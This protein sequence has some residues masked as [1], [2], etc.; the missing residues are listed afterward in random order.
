MGSSVLPSISITFTQGKILLNDS[1]CLSSDENYL[2]AKIVPNKTGKYIMSVK[3]YYMLNGLKTVEDCPFPKDIENCVHSRYKHEKGFSEMVRA[4]I[5]DLSSFERDMLEQ[6]YVDIFHDITLYEGI[7]CSIAAYIAFIWLLNRDDF[8]ALLPFDVDIPGLDNPID[9]T[10]F[11]YLQLP[12]TTMSRFLTG[13]LSFLSRLSLYCLNFI[14]SWG[15]LFAHSKT[16]DPTVMSTLCIDITS[17]FAAYID[18]QMSLYNN[19]LTDL[20]EMEERLNA[21]I[22]IAVRNL[23]RQVRNNGGMVEKTIPSRMISDTREP[24]QKRSKLEF[25]YD[26]KDGYADDTIKSMSSTGTDFSGFVERGKGINIYSPK[27]NAKKIL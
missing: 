5:K 6:Y 11:S 27:T 15:G 18:L 23:E 9:R 2:H 8:K 19:R 22:D 24:V 13:K 14:N 16:I 3:V 1:S 20:V 12:L 21:K 25:S 7:S 26:P 10:T 17:G 4:Y